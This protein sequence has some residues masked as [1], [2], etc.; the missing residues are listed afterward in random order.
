M[1]AIVG[2]PLRLWISA[3][4]YLY[5]KTHIT[6][7]HS[8]LLLCTYVHTISAYV[9]LESTYPFYVHL[10]QKERSN[11]QTSDGHQSCKAFHVF[12]CYAVACS[13]IHDAMMQG[14]W[15]FQQQILL[16]VIV[17]TRAT[18]VIMMSLLH[19]FCEITTHNLQR[20]WCLASRPHFWSTSLQTVAPYFSGVA[21]TLFLCFHNDGAHNFGGTAQTTRFDKQ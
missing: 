17:T 13:M 12:E 6:Q 19:I 20:Q 9:S 16:F 2:Y 18:V 4:C 14:Q 21:H 8:I 5:N 11:K 15:I 10:G 1:F 7:K 3:L